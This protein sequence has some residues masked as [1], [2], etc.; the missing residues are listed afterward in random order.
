MIQMLSGIE[1]DGAAFHHTSPN[2][3][4]GIHEENQEKLDV[5]SQ[6]ASPSPQFMSLH[7]TSQER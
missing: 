6:W 3:F 5:R 4:L 1:K 7:M 2:I